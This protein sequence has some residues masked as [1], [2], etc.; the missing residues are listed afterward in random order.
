MSETRLILRTKGE[1]LTKY[2]KQKYQ[3]L[4]EKEQFHAAN[5]IIR[6][7]NS[8]YQS[9]IDVMDSEDKLLANQIIVFN[10][11]LR[12]LAT[13]L[14]NTR[15]Q[16]K[17]FA[18]ETKSRGKQLMFE[19]EK[20]VNNQNTKTIAYSSVL[21]TCTKLDNFKLFNMTSS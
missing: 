1:L 2:D 8:D 6:K 17:A 7:Q 20:L 3:L 12:S 16:F 14:R 15:D 4:I 5:C 9:Q 11:G 13:N 19:L 18:A 21:Q 10:A